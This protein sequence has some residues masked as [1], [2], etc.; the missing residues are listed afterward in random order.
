VVSIDTSA[1]SYS[2]GSDNRGCA[3]IATSSGSFPMRISVGALS[4][5]VA[6]KGRI[7]EW[8]TGS[9][10]FVASGQLLKQTTSAFSTG[11]TGKYVFGITG[12]DHSGPVAMSCVGVMTASGGSFSSGQEDCNIGGTPD[13]QASM[14]GTYTT[15]DAS[16]RGTLS[17]VSSHG[18]SHIANYMVSS[19]KLL[20]LGTDDP[21]G[22][23]V[24]SGEMRSQSG[25]FNNASLNGIS[26]F[27][28]SGIKG[29]GVN[30]NAVIGLFTGSNGSATIDMYEDG[31]GTTTH[32]AFACSYTVASNGRVTLSGADCTPGPPLYLTAARAGIMETAGDSVTI[33]AV[34]AQAAGPFSTSS[35]SGTFFMGTNL[36]PSQSAEPSIGSV[37][38]NAGTVSGTSDVSSTNYQN[39]G[40]TFT[41]SYSI[42]STGWVTITGDGTTPTALVISGNKTVKIDPA[43]SSNPIPMLLIMEK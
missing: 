20:M 35:I 27:Y 6:T 38:M 37:T 12:E 23:P 40:Q 39:A 32:Q 25:T 34:E 11:V 15:L 8:E 28:L 13:N 36:V 24:Y 41:D 1:S 14:T 16:G 33:G 19:S 29:D 21:S 31:A 7:I 22:S 2:V 10:A 42:N 3:V 30:G 43:G 4:S 9:T 26:V 18:T 17:I 5:N